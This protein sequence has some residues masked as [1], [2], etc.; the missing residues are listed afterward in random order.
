MPSS[1]PAESPL[2]DT[3]PPESGPGVKAITATLV[4]LLVGALAMMAV[5]RSAPRTGGDLPLLPAPAGAASAGDAEALTIAAAPPPTTLAPG[6]RAPA[7]DAPAYRLNPGASDN[8]ATALSVALGITAGSESRSDERRVLVV[9]KDSDRVLHISQEPGSPW[10]LSRGDPDCFDRPDSSVSSDGSISCAPSASGGSE[11]GQVDGSE[12]SQGVGSSGSSGSSARQS[13]EAVRCQPVDCPDG[14]ACA[15]VCA[16]PTPAEDIPPAEPVELPSPEAAETRTREVLRALGLQV[17]RTTL[18][19]APDGTSWQ[20]LAEVSVGGI[21]A[22]GMDTHLSIGEG[23]DVVA[24]SGM[25]PDVELLGRYPLVDAQ[26]A[27]SR[28]QATQ[29]PTSGVPGVTGGLEPD[30]GAPEPAIAPEFPEAS[31]PTTAT[32]IRLVLLLQL[33]NLE[34]RSGSYLVPAYL[35]DASDGSVFTVAAATDEYL[36]EPEVPPFPE[37]VPLPAP[38]PES[39]QVDTEP[40]RD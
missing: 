9:D 33:G 27:L 18:S 25:L 40:Q 5:A 11:P 1:E 23:G 35:I 6:V 24:G 2:T 20:V 31:G 36:A 4:I 39:P 19:A 17:V 30:V 26:A 3:D 16:E 7:T 22:V 14:Q 29:S 8:I 32:G 12:P 10:S 37:P 13:D 34:D 15:Q 21:T 28:L 38:G